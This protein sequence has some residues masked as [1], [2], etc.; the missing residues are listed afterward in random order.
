MLG[1]TSSRATSPEEIDDASRTLF[2]QEV[3]ASATRHRAGRRTTGQLS[4][5]AA[6]GERAE[7]GVGRFIASAGITSTELPFAFTAQ[8]GRVSSGPL[9]ER[10]S[11]GGNPPTMLPAGVLSQ[12]ITQPGLPA[13]FV[14]ERLE[15]YRLAVPFAGARLYGWAGRA[16][17]DGPA[18]PLERVVGAEWSASIAAISA[19][20]TPA[21]RATIGVGHWIDR[22]VLTRQVPLDPAV[23]IAPTGDYRFYITTQFGD[24]SR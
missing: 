9:S 10:F 14:G 17:D 3:S 20:G 6:M 21:A 7:E 8:Y 12:F 11:I 16:Y 23:Y 19:L 22:R 5:H 1:G 15:T 24:W 2:F 13:F 18:P 4:M